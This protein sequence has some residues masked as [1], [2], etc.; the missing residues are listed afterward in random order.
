MDDDSRLINEPKGTV[1]EAPMVMRYLTEQ[2]I[3]PRYF[4]PRICNIRKG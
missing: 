4:K 3:R 2:A 1:V